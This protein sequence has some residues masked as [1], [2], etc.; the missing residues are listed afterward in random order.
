MSD[1]F[2]GGNGKDFTRNVLLE[3]QVTKYTW[4]GV[5]SWTITEDGQSKTTK[6]VLAKRELKKDKSGNVRTGHCKGLSLEDLQII[7]KNK[8][9][10]KPLLQG[11]AQGQA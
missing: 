6:P 8:E 4:M 11:A 7:F 2:G 10:V 1:D 3:L 9:K 5:E